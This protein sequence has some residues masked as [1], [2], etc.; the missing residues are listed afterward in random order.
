MTL[1]YRS[2]RGGRM[3]YLVVGLDVELDLLAGKCSYSIAF[4]SSLV[5]PPYSGIARR[6]CNLLDLHRVCPSL[7]SRFAL[8]GL[9]F[10]A[11]GIR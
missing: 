7:N 3:A 2:A 1:C 9:R 11:S 4:V 5:L 10:S 6:A 8:S